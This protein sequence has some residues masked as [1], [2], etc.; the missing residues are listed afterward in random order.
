MLFFVC[1]SRQKRHIFDCLEGCSLEKPKQRATFPDRVLYIGEGSPRG[2]EGEL[3]RVN[4]RDWRVP[5]LVCEVG[6]TT[7]TTHLDEKKNFT[8]S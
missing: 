1:F 5:D 7:L 4:L 8:R 3:R 2:R 6:D